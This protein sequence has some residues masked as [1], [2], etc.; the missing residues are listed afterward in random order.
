MS[1]ASRYQALR[2][3]A[4]DQQGQPEGDLCA[5]MAAVMLER[6][7][8]LAN[9]SAPDLPTEHREYRWKTPTDRSVLEWVIRAQGAAPKAYSKGHR[10]QGRSRVLLADVDEPTHA[11]I[12]YGYEVLRERAASA[13][14][15]A[16]MGF[17]HGAMPQPQVDDDDDDDPEP[18]DMAVLEMMRAGYALGTRSRPQRALT[19][20]ED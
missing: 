11:A 1:T 3:R 20:G 10:G 12:E 18:L 15:H 9:A 5:R 8:E 14:E 19:S 7:P 13:V 4:A 2:S 6:Y 16:L 17:L